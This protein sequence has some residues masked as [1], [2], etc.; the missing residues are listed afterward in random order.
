MAAN[1]SA[2]ID[3]RVYRRFSYARNRLLLWYQDQIVCL[4]N[5]LKE[6]DKE[7]FRK[8]NE[9]DAEARQRLISRRFDERYRTVRKEALENLEATLEKYDNLL[10]REHEIM[11]I[12]KAPA[13]MHKA[14]FDFMWD[15]KKDADGKRRKHLLPSEYQFMYR[16]D[17][18]M[19]LGNQDDAWLGSFAESVK[20]LLP[21]K[22]R[23][24]LLASKEDREKNAGLTNTTFLTNDRIDTFVKGTVCAANT[25]LL[26][27]PIVILY[28]MS[29]DGAS[30]WLKIGV[31]LIFV[32]IFAFLLAALTNASRNDLLAGSAG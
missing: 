23:R 18:F 4:E 3:G 14:M 30:G 28:A 26:V 22:I 8:G 13:K 6:L 32:V 29:I 9:G 1:I 12:K 17:D 27:V 20:Y 21:K 11:S 7:D 19:I 31:L 24:T 25:V 15:G 16:T 10:L 2:D 5:D